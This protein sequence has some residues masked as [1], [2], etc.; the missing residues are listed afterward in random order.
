VRQRS[1]IEQVLDRASAPGHHAG[2]NP[3]RWSGHLEH[4]LADPGKRTP[5]RHHAAMPVALLPGSRCNRFAP[6]PA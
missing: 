2:P 5:P 1:R 3:A 4:I 6:S